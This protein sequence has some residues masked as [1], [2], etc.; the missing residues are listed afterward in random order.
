MQII[1]VGG[2]DNNQAELYSGILLSNIVMGI[3]LLITLAGEDI[4]A[5][6][7]K[8][9]R[10]LTTT[11][12]LITEFDSEL[13][14]RIKS[15]WEDEGIQNVWINKKESVLYQMEYLMSNFDRILSVDFV[16]TNDDILRARQRSSGENMHRF[17]DKDR[18][19]HL[20]DVGG[21]LSERE[22]WDSVLGNPIQAIIFFLALDEYDVENPE[23]SKTEYPT[24]FQLA[25]SVF[26]EVMNGYLVSEHKAS[27][28]VFL[29]KLDLFTTKIQDENRFEDFRKR[30]HYTGGK[31]ANECVEF[32]TT[33]LNNRINDTMPLHI[34]SV[35]ALDTSLIKKLT[36]DI[37]VSIIASSLRDMGIL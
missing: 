18:I 4:S 12:D 16:P 25:L 33:N 22:K 6:N 8:K 13:R 15:L 9:A 1:H 14:E 7:R 2:F 3:K 35:C 27:R 28:I 36:Q 30:L 10:F 34:H 5:E 19:W 24:K 29:N 23:T 21:Q 32:I 11:E 20:V 26:D 37:K 17:E 31:N